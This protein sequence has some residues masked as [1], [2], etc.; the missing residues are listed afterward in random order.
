MKYLDKCLYLS[1][2]H[3]TFKKRVGRTGLGKQSKTSTTSPE[4]T[5]GQEA[6]K[7]YYAFSIK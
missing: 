1:S 6:S 3:I 7:R 4:H 2:L 5:L